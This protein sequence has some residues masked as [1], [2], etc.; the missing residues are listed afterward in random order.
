MI[1]LHQ[2]CGAHHSPTAGNA[3]GFRCASGRSTRAPSLLVS[4]FV[5]ITLA[6]QGF[7]SRHFTHN[8]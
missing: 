2:N 7:L 4:N 6:E 5:Q 1:G 8:A 3:Q